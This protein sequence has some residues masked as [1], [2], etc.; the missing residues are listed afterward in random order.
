MELKGTDVAKLNDLDLRKSLG[1]HNVTVGPV[2]SECCNN[3]NIYNESKHF[4]FV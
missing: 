4:H 1:E 2:T 3:E